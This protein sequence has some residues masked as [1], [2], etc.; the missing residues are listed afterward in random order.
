MKRSSK[1]GVLAVGVI[2]GGLAGALIGL[3]IDP[4]KGSETRADLKVRTTALRSRAVEMASRG[5]S[6]AGERASEGIAAVKERARPIY[7]GVRERI[8][9]VFGQTGSPASDESR[10]VAEGDKDRPEARSD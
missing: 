5:K 1:N 3:L 9:P 4:K 2:A 7:S 10:E 6:Q 8:S